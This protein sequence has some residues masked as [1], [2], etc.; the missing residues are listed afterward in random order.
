MRSLLTPLGWLYGGA[1][2]LRNRAFDAGVLS[3]H[4]L[5]LPSISVGNLTVGGKPI[6]DVLEMKGH[7]EVI[8]EILRMGKGDA[9]LSE[10]RICK[11]HRGIMH[12]EDESKRDRIGNWKTEPN[13]LYNYKNLLND[14]RRQLL[15][16]TNGLQINFN[17]KCLISCKTT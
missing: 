8:T 7:D 11:I 17:N 10:A 13:Y 16:Y 12:E 6:Q 15:F 1:T 4:A 5:A 3:T 14:Y 9:R 2:A